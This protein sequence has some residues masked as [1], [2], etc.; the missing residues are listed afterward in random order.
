MDLSFWGEFIQPEL[1]A[2]VPARCFFGALLK[3]SPAVDDHKIPLLLGI[4]GIL[5]AAVWTLGQTT[6]RGLPAVMNALFTAV[7][8]GLLCAGA[9][10]YLHQLVHQHHKRQKERAQPAAPTPS[11]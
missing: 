1:L 3:R 8:Q 10:V 7:V 11:P 5:I 6:P 4:A 9:S 2:V